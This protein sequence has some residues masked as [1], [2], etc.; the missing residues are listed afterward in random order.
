[1]AYLVFSPVL[2]AEEVDAPMIDDPTVD[3]GSV[4]TPYEEGMAEQFGRP[5]MGSTRTI[6]P[7]M[8]DTPPVIDG[9]L[10]DEVWRTAPVSGGFWV[11][12]QERWPDEKTEVMILS[13]RDTI[14]VAFRAYDS[15]LDEVRAIQS[16]RDR[17]LGF[18]D[19]V[20]VEIDTFGDHEGVSRFYVNARGTQNDSIAGGRASRISWKGDWDV[21]V[22]RTD[23]GWTAEFAIPYEILNYRPDVEEFS[24]NFARYHSRAQQWSRWA[25]IT[26]QN[27]HE[28]MGHLVGISAPTGKSKDTWTFMPF[29]L[30]GKNVVDREGD[31]QD[32]M[33]TGGMDILYAPTSNLT[34]VLSLNPDFTQVETQIT[35]VNFSYNEKS[36]PD[37]R[38]FFQEGSAY[39]GNDNRIFYS[40][41]VPDFN[42][43]GKMFGQEGDLRYGGF[44]TFAPDS[45][46]DGVARLAYALDQT[47]GGSLIFI[48]TDREDLDGTTVA[49]SADGRE[50]I[51][52]FW[53]VDLASTYNKEKDE[54]SENGSMYDVR[55]GWQGD[56]WGGGVEFDEYDKDFIPANALIKTDRL[57]TNG[58]DTF[59]NYYRNFGDE[60]VSENTLNIVHS[61]RETDDGRTQFK[62]WYLA[63]TMEWLSY[64]RTG[65]EYYDGDYRP[66]TGIAP[67]D[68]SDQ[69]NHD[70]YWTMSIDLNTRGSRIGYGGFYS[71][72]DLGG[73]DYEYLYGYVWTRPTTNTSLSVSVERL[74][75][76]GTTRQYVTEG[77]WDITPT[78]SLV[79]RHI[80][81]L[82]DNYWRLGYLRVVRR[83]LDIFMLYDKEP[84]GETALSLKLLWTIS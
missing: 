20:V 16:V 36:V 63:G 31:F 60:I 22:A 15:Q 2:A 1:L 19:Q 33:F 56:Y 77:G 30:A 5:P 34:G 21:A 9:R 10:D 67:G 25:D 44:V 51:G 37:P 39:Y 40:P 64:A 57:G 59:V 42:G 46:V 54:D 72:G 73:G 62:G 28:E 6:M 52:T 83:G 76:F 14:Y 3:V 70:H 75:S 45:R 26:P 7:I 43:G 66:V 17:G 32:E 24:I 74:E 58:L 48:N 50:Q 71:S 4:L 61:D 80:Y 23:Y 53:D 84:D 47:H 69:V 81:A 68:F 41:K 65:L 82:D 27:K 8:I 12:T 18:D 13:D 38:V 29:V 49:F 11:T 79:F 35:N 55:G 78:N